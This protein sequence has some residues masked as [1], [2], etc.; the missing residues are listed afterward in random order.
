MPAGIENESKVKK[1]AVTGHDRRM[2]RIVEA[3]YL[4]GK[5]QEE[6]AGAEGLSRQMITKIIQ[7]ARERGIVTFYIRSP[8]DEA[9]LA[10][11]GERLRSLLPL[12]DLQIVPAVLDRPGTELQLS[13]ETVFPLAQ[14]AAQYLDRI[15]NQG[16]G[17][18]LVVSPGRIIRHV[19]AGLRPEC[20]RD[21]LQVVPFIGLFNIAGPP[22]EASI[23]A[24]E[25]ARAYGAEHFFL[26]AEAYIQDPELKARLEQL[27]GIRKA[28]QVARAAD[29][30]VTGI[31]NPLPTLLRKAQLLEVSKEQQ[32]KLARMMPELEERIVGEIAGQAFDQDGSLIEELEKI[33]GQIVGLSLSELRERVQAGATSIGVVGGD[34]DRVPGI[35]AAIRAQYINALITDDLTAR[36]LIRLAQASTG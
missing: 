9:Q 30:I 18:R 15:L 14:R 28:L 6:I 12:K 22:Y 24:W 36:E 2:L 5:K 13:S 25:L 31:G 32:A 10:G 33:F 4:E 35:L 34:L 20:L 19:V 1:G 3:Y 16:K 23:L 29:L 26:P 27:P 21:D 8:T 17:K 11:L 7:Q